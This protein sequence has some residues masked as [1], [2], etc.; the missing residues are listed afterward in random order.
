MKSSRKKIMVILSNGSVTFYY[1]NNKNYNKVT[2]LKY[3]FLNT[4]FNKESKVKYGLESHR[5]AKTKYL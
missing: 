2:Y 3:D 1:I 5:R 4:N